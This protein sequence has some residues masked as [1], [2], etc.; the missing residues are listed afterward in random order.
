MATVSQNKTYEKQAYSLLEN[1]H[2]GQIMWGENLLDKKLTL[3]PGRIT[4]RNLLRIS[5]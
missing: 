5:K 2:A 3:F 4:L 1:V